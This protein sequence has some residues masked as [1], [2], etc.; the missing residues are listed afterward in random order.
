MKGRGVM[1]ELLA[2]RST[3]ALV[4]RAL[5]L[6][7]MELPDHPWKALLREPGKPPCPVPDYSTDPGAA[8]TLLDPLRVAGWSFDLRHTAEVVEVGADP[9]A[10]PVN[11]WS[12]R[13]YDPRDEDAGFTVEADS[14]PLAICRA[15]LAWVKKGE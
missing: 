3:D 9:K 13:V 8:M 12:V 7:V 15:F 5:G 10:A 4:A 11:P 6:E 1:S 2:G 14:L